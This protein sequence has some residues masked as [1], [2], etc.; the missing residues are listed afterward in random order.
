[1]VYLSSSQVAQKP[2]LSLYAQP[3]AQ[4]RA[5]PGLSTQKLWTEENVS[6][7]HIKNPV[8]PNIYITGLSFTVHS[9]HLPLNFGSF[10]KETENCRPQ[11]GN[12]LPAN[13]LLTF[14]LAHSC[15]WTA[16][17]TLSPPEY[18]SINCSHTRSLLS[19]YPQL[20]NML[21]SFIQN[22]PYYD[23]KLPLT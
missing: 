20:T 14:T 19:N 22:T 1:M 12:V 13:T 16:D 4:P 17:A 6:I 15:P 3:R 7:S 21:T 11:G 5:Q 10:T 8:E 2:Q 9:L 18:C 23:V